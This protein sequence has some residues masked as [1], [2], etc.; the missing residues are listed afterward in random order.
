MPLYLKSLLRFLKK[1]DENT[2]SHEIF[3]VEYKM[4]N[5]HKRHKHLKFAKETGY[6]VALTN[7]VIR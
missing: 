6:F 1:K 2:K 5:I 3:S 4:V 7:A